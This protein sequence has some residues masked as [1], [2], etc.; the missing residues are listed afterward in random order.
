[1]PKRETPK[2]ETSHPTPAEIADSYVQVAMEKLAKAEAEA[3]I[4]AE[5]VK[6]RSPDPLE[7]SIRSARAKVLREEAS[8]AAQISTGMSLR[9]LLDDRIEIA[10]AE[11]S[12]EEL[13]AEASRALKTGVEDDTGPEHPHQPGEA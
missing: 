12:P 13:V 9:L 1:M 2:K 7:T 3:E 11:M 8:I 4:A 6:Q 5:M 10:V